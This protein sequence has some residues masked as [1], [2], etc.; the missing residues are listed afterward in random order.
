M[1]SG[2]KRMSKSMKTQYNKKYL[3]RTY[4]RIPASLYRVLKA[5]DWGTRHIGGPAELS[6]HEKSRNCMA[7]TRWYT[8]TYV[9][10]SKS[11]NTF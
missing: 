5:N 4:C 7:T 11:G 8:P 2:V 9:P 10:M 3:H 6:P 1:L